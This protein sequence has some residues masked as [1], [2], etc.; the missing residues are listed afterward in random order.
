MK[1]KITWFWNLDKRIWGD[2]IEANRYFA[3]L[4]IMYAVLMGAFTG[5]GR[6]FSEWF[7]WNTA[8][9][10]V[11][12]GALLIFIWG[13]NLAES[14]VASRTAMVALWRSLLLLLILILA[15]VFGVV[16]SVVAIFLVS[17]WIVLSFIGYALRSSGGSGRRSGGGSGV[18]QYGYDE[19]GSQHTMRDIGGGYAKDEN[20][21]RWKNGG[22]SKWHLDE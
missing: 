15:F 6:V 7:G 17:A 14:I 5:G 9:S 4:S 12:M 2:K 22:G 3:T 16:T 8:T 10:I 18:E 11:A 13:V 1:E 21:N 20:G 19:N